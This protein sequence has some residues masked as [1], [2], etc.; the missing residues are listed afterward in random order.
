[1][2]AQGHV[3]IFGG[4]FGGTLHAHLLETDA[5]RPLAGNLIVADG[6]QLQMAFCERTHVVAQ[7]RL[8][9][10]GLKQRRA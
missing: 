5:L 9:H 1:M 2:Q 8:E 7:M 3:G 10:V 6:R 4:I